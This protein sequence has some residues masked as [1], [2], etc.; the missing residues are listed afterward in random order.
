VKRKPKKAAKMEKILTEVLGN[1]GKIS[2]R[3]LYSKNIFL[4]KA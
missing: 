3:K 2:L 1:M 4:R